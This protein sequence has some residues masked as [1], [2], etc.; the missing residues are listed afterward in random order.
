MTTYAYHVTFFDRWCA[1]EDEGLLPSQEPVVGVYD[2]AEHCACKVFFTDEAGLGYWR[3]F[4]NRAEWT[5]TRGTVTVV[6]FPWPAD[7]REDEEPNPDG[8]PAWY[9]TR[10]IPATQ[11]VEVE[12]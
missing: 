2:L 3:E 5:R 11:I 1:I 8:A 9:V 10:E 4:F 7:A 12:E 6:R